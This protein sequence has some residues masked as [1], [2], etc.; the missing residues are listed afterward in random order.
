M[1]GL[2]TAKVL[3]KHFDNVIVIEKDAIEPSWA[4]KAAAET[5][6]VSEVRNSNCGDSGAPTTSCCNTQVWDAA[7]IY[8]I[9]VLSTTHRQE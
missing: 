3:S 7:F 4:D 6:Q 1:G 2:A 5:A 8:C 9:T